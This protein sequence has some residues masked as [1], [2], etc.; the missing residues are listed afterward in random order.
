MTSTLVLYFLSGLFAREDNIPD[1]MRTAAGLFPVKPLFE[2][3]LVAYD[4]ATTGTGFFWRDLAVL[5][6]WGIAGLVLGLR[7][8]RWSPATG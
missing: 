1:T 6:A 5:A 3:L 7:F 8:F 2:A 4:P